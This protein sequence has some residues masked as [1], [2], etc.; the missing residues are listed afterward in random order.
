MR[1]GLHLLKAD[2]APEN[3]PIKFVASGMVL[4]FPKDKFAFKEYSKE[5]VLAV[6]TTTSAPL[7]IST[8]LGLK[9]IAEAN[10]PLDLNQM[11]N[12]GR[13]HLWVLKQD[14]T[15]LALTKAIPNFGEPGEDIRSVRYIN[16]HAYVVTFKKTDPLYSFDM[17]N[18]ADPV[19]V[20][21]LKI[22]GF[23][24][25]L[26]PAK[27]EKMIG[28]GF[29]AEDHGGFALYQGIQVSLFDISNKS[30]VLQ[31]DRIVHG[32]RGS[33]SDVTRNPHAFF[34]SA[35]DNL[36]A[37]PMVEI[38]QFSGAVIYGVDQ[39]KLV[40][41]GRISHQGMIPDKC[42][43]DLNRQRWWEET[44]VSQD[45]NRVFKVDQ[46]LLS[47][48]KYGI[49]KFKIDDFSVALK[50]TIFDNNKEFCPVRPSWDFGF[51]D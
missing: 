45:I 39:D 46:H 28:V 2:I 49:K 5:D 30:N 21:K 38:D 7:P 25:Y 29:D 26:H 13:N 10:D 19:M 44:A 50:T 20:G 15:R 51:S 22:P 8:D 6:A 33:Y 11:E 41:L 24:L 17:S 31:T 36:M 16:D 35:A 43:F 34:Y 32:E 9:N 12:K 27:D 18:P 4:G 37:I 48:S 3:G 47:I 42:L 1:E 23:S 40:E 14:G